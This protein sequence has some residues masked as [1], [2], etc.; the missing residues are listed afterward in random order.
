MRYA[1][2]QN[3]T[4]VNTID[5]PPEFAAILAGYDAV[6]ASDE[7]C[8]GWAWDGKAFAPPL[9]PEPSPPAPEPQ[10]KRKTRSAA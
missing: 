4:V 8:I 7:A 2:I 1:L 10:P 9:A 6:I 5:A 3:G